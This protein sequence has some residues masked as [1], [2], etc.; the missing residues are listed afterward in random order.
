MTTL[1]PDATLSS[2]SIDPGGQGRATAMARPPM[3]I[4][5]IASVRHGLREP[6]AGG[7]ER[8]TA[9]LANTLRARGHDVTV[10]ASADSDPDLGV[11]PICD[12]ESKL[13]LSTA[14]RQ[15]VS[16]LSDRFLEEHHAY[17]HLMLRLQ[18]DGFDV[19]HD[20]SLH[21]LPVALAKS[22]P[23][24]VVKVL[25]TPPTPW[26]ESA[27]VRRSDNVSLI[28]VSHAN[29][30]RWPMPV[31]GVIHNAVDTQ[32]FRPLGPPHLD[33]VWF[34]RIVP[35]KAPHLALEAA[36]D[37]DCELVL[38]GP[39][40]D[41]NYYEAKVA[42]LLDDRRVH[43]GH[44]GRVQLAELVAASRVTVA[45]PAWDEPYGLVVAESLACGTP[46]VGLAR[47][48]LPELITPEIGVLVDGE[49]PARIGRAMLQ[50]QRLDRSACRSWALENAHLDRMVDDYL[51]HYRLVAA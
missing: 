35:E 20:N 51:D 43:A 33:A 1:V 17:L 28:S 45:T 14:A 40:G 11:E 41:R 5:L 36:H 31:D 9:D 48:A 49:D 47:G 37:I 24:P 23:T 6:H 7:L 21:Y 34:G 16:M 13:D 12:E 38:A 4:A 27:L 30:G 18:D 8:H 50:A 44:L 26:L 29:A 46:V 42:P 15:D 25:H 22:I 3:R 19:V 2:D 32:A 39:V 10:F